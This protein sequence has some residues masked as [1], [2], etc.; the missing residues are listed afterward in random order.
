MVKKIYDSSLRVLQE[1][2]ISLVRPYIRNDYYGWGRVYAVLVGDYQRDWL[3][4]GAPI[5]AMRGKL[6][7]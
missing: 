2:I 5:S 7:G 6:H 3:W 1:V 4:K